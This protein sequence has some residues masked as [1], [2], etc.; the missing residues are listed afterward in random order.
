MNFHK[1]ILESCIDECIRSALPKKLQIKSSCDCHEYSRWSVDKG[2]GK[3]VFRIFR[4]RPICNRGSCGLALLRL[5]V[6]RFDL[7]PRLHWVHGSSRGEGRFLLWIA[8]DFLSLLYLW[9]SH[10]P[11]IPFRLP[12]L[13]CVPAQKTAFTRLS[14]FCGPFL[15]RPNGLIL[16]A[17]VLG[18]RRRVRFKPYSS[19]GMFFFQLGLCFGSDIGLV[20]I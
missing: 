9:L 17:I 8:F 6:P 15:K 11:V 12:T 19:A 5:C 4:R 18:Q 3:V 1:Y 20:F 16:Q 7:G 14:H 2:C 10:Y 13:V